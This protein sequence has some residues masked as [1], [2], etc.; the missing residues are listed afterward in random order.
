MSNNV[1]PF[2]RSITGSNFLTGLAVG[3]VTALVVTNPNVQRAFFRSAVKTAGLV[4][5]GVAEV[6]ERFHDAEAEVRLESK[7]EQ[8]TA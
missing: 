3:A 1:G 7:E 8:E 2:M 6:K 5:A 4:T